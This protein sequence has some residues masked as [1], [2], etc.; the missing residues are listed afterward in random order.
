MNRKQLSFLLFG[1][2][3]L[4]LSELFPPWLYENEDNSALRSAGYHFRM[5]PPKVKAPTEMRKIFQLKETDT[6]QF[7]WVRP[8]RIGMLGQ[9]FALICAALGGCLIFMNRRIWLLYVLGWLSAGFAVFFVAVLI[10]HYFFELRP[11]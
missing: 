11:S 4:T 8:D 1:V 5:S 2:I 9:R 10:F 7:I 3:L 6:T